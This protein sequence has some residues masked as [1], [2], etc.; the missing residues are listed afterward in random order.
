MTRNNT[1][2]ITIELPIDLANRFEELAKF[3]G[4]TESQLF[5]DMFDIYEEM[6]AEREWQELRRYGS[7]KA[8]EQG[9]TSEQDINRLIHEFRAERDT[10]MHSGGMS[11]KEID[12][13]IRE[14]KGN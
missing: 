3:A 7:Q 12:K 9:I 5:Q 6:T 11:E 13:I 8:K 14:A 2:T 10:G 4:K 1:T